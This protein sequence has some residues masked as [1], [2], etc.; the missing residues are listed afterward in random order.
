MPLAEGTRRRAGRRR[1]GLMI[2]AGDMRSVGIRWMAHRRMGLDVRA[3]SACPLDQVFM[4][5]NATGVNKILVVDLLVD[6]SGSISV[7]VIQNR[8]IK[9]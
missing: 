9:I 4:D 2:G 6:E 1:R 5:M 7:W 3:I 8:W